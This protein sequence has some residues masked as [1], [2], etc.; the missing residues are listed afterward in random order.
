M[1]RW[2]YFLFAAVALAVISGAGYWGYRS[3]QTAVP[4]QPP[5]PVTI[6]AT[7]GDVQKTVTAP[8]QLVGTQQQMLGMDVDGR[9]IELNVRPGTAVSAGDVI[10]QIDPT[11]YENALNIAQIELAQAQ[12]ALAQQL[13]QAE[14]NAANSE[15]Q[16]GAVQAQFPQLTAAEVNLN[17]AREAEAWAE[18]EYNKALDRHWEPPE[19]VEAYRVEWQHA[20]ANRQIAESEYNA[21]LNQQWAVGQQVEAQQTELDR[22]KSNVEYLRES[23]VDPLLA[24]AVSQAEANLAATVLRAP[25]DGVV[26]DVFVTPG[27]AVGAGTNLVLLADPS[28]GEVRTTVIEEDL[29]DVQLGQPA[30][31]FFD[32]RP[33]LAV[34]GTVARLVPQRVI[35]EARPLYHV[36]ITIDERLPDGVFPGMTVDASIIVDEMLETV[37]LPRTLLRPRSDGTAV[38]VLW[39]NG[40]RVEREV[41]VGLRGD[42]FMAIESGLQPGDEVVG[43]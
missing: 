36:Y 3:Q 18:N 6:A 2:I 10:A 42:V 39:Q 11:P 8:G 34:Q 23:G 13:V 35:G 29:A 20:I 9:L 33:D 38:V 30:E 26:L 17:L 15:A 21:V 1:K 5:A 43:E 7:Q 41:T 14:L 22:A 32:A 4:T 19:V 24:T 16:V 25:F 37:R 31:L 27:E 12:E 28:L 40:Q